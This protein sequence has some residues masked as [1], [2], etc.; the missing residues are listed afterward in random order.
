MKLLKLNT[1][2]RELP[3]QVTLS[4]D[5]L[6]KEVESSAND[7]KHPNH[8]SS[9]AILEQLNQ[10]PELRSG[11]ED[12]SQLDQYKEIFDLLFKPL[13]P[14]ALQQ[15]EIK[16]IA[17]PFTYDVFYPTKRFEAILDHAGADYQ[18]ILNGFNIDRSYLYACSYIL[19]KY[20]GQSVLKTSRPTY[21]DI[22]DQRTGQMKHY[23]TLFNAD[24][25][26]IIKTDKAPDLTQEDIDALIIHGNDLDLW[27][28]KF[29]PDSYI[30]KGFG[31]MNLFD[32]TQDVI[33][34]KTRSLFLRTDEQVFDD[35]EKEI[36]RLYGIPDL[37]VGLSIYNTCKEKSIGHF[38]NTESRSLFINDGEAL[39]YNQF[40]CKGALCALKENNEIY[41]VSDV[42]LYGRNTNQNPFYKKLVEKGIKS[43]ILVPIKIKGD[44]LQVL[45]VASS[46]KNE[47]NVI[48][49]SR[50]EDIVPFVK[51]ASERYFEES[52]NIIESTIQENYT[53]IHP[54]VK[55]RF[56]EAVTNF[57]AQKNNGIENPVLEDIIFDKIYPLYGQ[58]DIVG[59]SN[60]RN[61]AIQADLELQLSLVIDT[62]KKVMSIQDFP[63]YK[64]MIF[65]VQ[66]CLSEV[67]KGLKSGD[68]VEILSFLKKEIYPVFNH[69]KTLGAEFAEAVEHYIE[70]I[71]PDLKVVYRQRK[72]YEATVNLLNEKLAGFL[73]KQQEVAQK[74]FPHYFERYKT[75]GVEYNM[76]I[77]DSLVQDRTFNEMYLHNLR[78][79]QL[80]MMCQIENVAYKLQRRME[81]PLRVASLILVHSN[82]LAIKFRMDEKQFDVDGAYNVRYEIIKKRIDKSL[83]KGTKE[84]LTV[85]GKIAIVY[86]QESD[87]LEY[88]NYI[89]Y[90]QSENKLGKVEM[91]ELHDMQGVS[92]LKAI[93]VE[94]IY[95]EIEHKSEKNKKTRKDIVTELG[96]VT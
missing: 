85:A 82:S 76:Y 17:L 71:D 31:I 35:F 26:E 70:Q 7:K 15:N 64:K 44:L 89:E 30:L 47:L 12:L 1:A 48:S 93:R 66:G 78:L 18:M 84:R 33:I 59:S 90:L 92:G 74:M 38:Y 60:A 42:D 69:L 56:V 80:E 58:S 14:E 21:L 73:D 43:I 34:S 36:Q 52:E 6:Y 39:N 50:L 86:A 8:H 24:F 22:P 28:E 27:K 67:R 9:K 11:L 55:W 40:F 51:I 91:L 49:G 41:A 32:S 65:K 81:Y 23:R 19:A 45:E 72:A 62:F 54:T 29:P 61:T 96:V 95:N 53:S 10:F 57:N 20:Y 87:A 46:R 79:W 25:I 75:D 5:S 3:V 88:L 2:S 37:K 16:A 13:F 77:G 68:E 4:L 83:V 63:I 94:V